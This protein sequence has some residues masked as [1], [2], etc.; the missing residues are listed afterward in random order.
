MIDY[1]TLSLCLLLENS[2]WYSS[3]S[4]CTT[5]SI[6]HAHVYINYT[7][8]DNILIGS[9]SLILKTLR[10]VQT[11]SLWTVWTLDYYFIRLHIDCTV[12]TSSKC[13]QRDIIERH[14]AIRIMI[15]IC[16]KFFYRSRY[17]LYLIQTYINAFNPEK[18]F[19]NL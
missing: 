12:F 3:R 8:N 13:Y 10:F 15:K 6:S 4:L 5:V 17:N 19:S 1:V 11:T 14:I 9:L 16:F 18:R 2:H 7:Y